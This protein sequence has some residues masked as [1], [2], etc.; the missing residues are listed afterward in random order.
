MSPQ[1]AHGHGVGG[2]VGGCDEV[3]HRLRLAEVE[4][5]IE[6]GPLCELPR[7]GLSCAVVDKG[8]QHA[9]DDVSRTV[10][11]KLHGIL[12]GVGM[13]GTKNQG[14]H[15]VDGLAILAYHL[16][17]VGGVAAGGGYGFATG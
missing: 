9:V 4:L 11:G 5:T 12:T 17:V 8:L 10:A 13:G 2:V 1:L 16:A 3:G 14:H 7:P 6:K 15:V